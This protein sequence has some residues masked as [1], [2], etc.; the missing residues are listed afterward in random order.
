MGD[1]IQLAK[2]NPSTGAITDTFPVEK[3]KLSGGMAYDAF[4]DTMFGTG[5]YDLDTAGPPWSEGLFSIDRNTGAFSVI[6]SGYSSYYGING[7]AVHPTT[8][9][10]Y[11]MDLD[12]D[13]YTFD[14]TTGIPTLIGGGGGPT[15]IY[16]HGLAF[17]PS[18]VLYASDTLGA[19]TS[20]IFQINISDGSASLVATIKYDYVVGLDFSSDGTLFGSDNGTASLI[21]IDL[22]AETGTTIGP[23]GDSAL[24]H[25]S[26]AFVP[27]VPE[28]TSLALMGLGLA[29]IGYKRHRSKKAA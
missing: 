6:G 11:G 29:G 1:S 25:N 16:R 17:S 13:L 19:G 7:L 2:V 20:D 26:I 10:L 24:G 15:I 22:L 8:N 9:I 27:S 18:G 14:K 5:L 28:P 4:T 21:T 12:G 3:Y 23:F